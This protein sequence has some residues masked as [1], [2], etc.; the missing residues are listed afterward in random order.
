MVVPGSIP[1]MMRSLANSYRYFCR[2]PDKH[3][4]KQYWVAFGKMAVLALAFY[5]IWTKLSSTSAADWAQFR[6]SFRGWPWE[7]VVVLLLLSVAN[8]TIEIFK[9]QNLASTLRTISWLESARQV[10]AALTAGIFTPNGIGEYGAKTLYFEKTQAGQVVLL[11]LVCNGI[12]MFWS[13]V[14]GL[15]GLL[16]FNQ[17][18][19][20]VASKYLFFL[21]GLIALVTLILVLMRKIKIRGFSFGDLWKKLRAIPSPVH[22]L[23]LILGFMRYLS[24][25]FQY[26][27]LF[28]LFGTELDLS[29]LFAGV[30]AVYLLASSLPSF[31]FLDFAVKGGVAILFFGPLGINEWIIASISTLMWFFN[32]VLP[33]SIGAYF[34]LRFKPV[35]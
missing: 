10:L 2:M 29:L 30:C 35:W 5:V 25:S 3:K 14:F 19:G 26:V 4:T 8:R 34:V 17:R 7:W 22:R 6:A 32:V 16:Y 27:L 33:V 15:A 21:F 11:N 23:N 12:Q 31:Q 1:K 18:T 13:I 28:R 20:L 24:F 9:W